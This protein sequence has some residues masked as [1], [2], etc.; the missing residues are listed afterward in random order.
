[1]KKQSFILI[2]LVCCF[3]SS[4][5]Y[6]YSENVKDNNYKIV[7]NETIDEINDTQADKIDSVYETDKITILKIGKKFA[8][9]D[10]ETDSMVFEPIIDEISAFNE[11]EYKVKVGNLV[12]YVNIE[13][14][15]NFLT[16]YDDINLFGNYIKTIKENKYGLIDKE[17]NII[18]KPIYEKVGLFYNDG[19]EYISAKYAGKYKLYQNTGKLIPEE[20]LYV[21]LNDQNSLLAINLKPELKKYRYNNAQIYQETDSEYEI[22]EVNMN[23]TNQENKTKKRNLIKEYIEM[24]PVEGKDNQFI[25]ANKIYT[26]IQKDNKYGIHTLKNKEIIPANY[27]QII[28]VEPTEKYKQ[29]IFITIENGIYSEYSIDGKLLA[30][31]VYDKLNIYK[32]G[33]LYIYKKENGIWTLRH[34]NQVIGQMN[35]Y[36]G[37]YKFNRIKRNTFRLNKINE[38]FIILSE[39]AI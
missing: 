20:D 39:H 34:N 11:N 31:Q 9:Y 7:Q 5:N 29:A 35:Y 22:K 33:K 36:N 13:N 24:N 4:C 1:M 37:V 8:I 17:S 14:K 19:K 15:N 12:G 6:S 10:K 21:V 2:L 25:F 30:E 32:N 23:E 28:P 26:L 27:D 16:N 18:L 3:F 38:L